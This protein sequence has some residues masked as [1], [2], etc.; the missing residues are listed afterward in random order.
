MAALF[1][2]F[3]KKKKELRSRKAEE[4]ASVIFLFTK[5][6]FPKISS[7]NIWQVAP[8]KISCLIACQFPC[9][10]LEPKLIF[11]LK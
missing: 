11:L 9:I 8:K 2:C 5:S 10:Y 4:N 3:R 7:S 1:V 6:T